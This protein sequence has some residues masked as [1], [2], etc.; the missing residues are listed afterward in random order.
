MLLALDIDGT[1]ATNGN[2]FVRWMTK[3]AG[4]TIP[5][6]D[7]A[8]TRYGFE[9]WD[10]P[11]VQAL[12]DDRR[13]ELLAYAH[14]HH[15]DP[16]NQD[17]SIPIPGAR[18]TLQQL[19]EKGANIIYTTCRQTDAGPRTS[20]WLQRYAF[21]SPEKVFICPRYHWK[22]VHAHAHSGPDDIILLIDDQIEKMVPA[23]RTL[24]LEKRDI[25]IS[26]VRRLA[27]V[28]IGQTEPPPFKK[29]PFKVL[30]LPS[31]RPEDVERLAS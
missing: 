20:A 1:V 19:T 11:Q 26:L 27:V 16:E 10:L 25:A 29:A 7:L 15:K 4:I 28:A 3:E 12:G 13:A 2:W 14:A 21:P 8:R 18:E 5:E 17:N 24:A 30:A 31:W 23:F 22:Y 9:F 6:D